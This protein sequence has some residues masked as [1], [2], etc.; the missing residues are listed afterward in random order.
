[1]TFVLLLTCA[2]DL[3]LGVRPLGCLQDKRDGAGGAGKKGKGR[4]NDHDDEDDEMLGHSEDDRDSMVSE[5][6]SETGP[7]RGGKSSKKAPSTT[8]TNAPS[9]KTGAAQEK[10]VA[11]P[12]AAKG[13]SQNLVSW[14]ERR[15]T[16]L[17]F[18]G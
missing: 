14:S 15:R 6:S 4:A 10:S 2:L 9:K 8:T 16:L 5:R 12:A 13:R 7:S 18:V 17:A 1:M 11:K 3:A